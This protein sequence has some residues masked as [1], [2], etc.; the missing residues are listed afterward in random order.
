[1]PKKGQIKSIYYKNL[2]GI[3]DLWA[4]MEA[5]AGWGLFGLVE[6]R[7][8]GVGLVVGRDGVIK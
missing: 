1:M 4:R 3:I 2:K 7:G 6:R 8:A 5:D